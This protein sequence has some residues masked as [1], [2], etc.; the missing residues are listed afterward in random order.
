[1][2]ATKSV[3]DANGRFVKGHVG[4]PGR[5]RRPVEQEYLATLNGA[6]TLDAWREIVQRAIEDA[7]NGEAKARDWLA[8][9]LLGDSP[10]SLLEL[11]AREEAGLTPG[12][13]IGAAAGQIAVHAQ[14]TQFRSD[15][16]RMLFPQC[17]TPLGKAE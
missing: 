4:G 9:Y 11:A 5:P 16:G 12:S 2:P 1:M 13:E 15:L 7:K 10:P 8:K 17:A 6:V 3:R 14:V